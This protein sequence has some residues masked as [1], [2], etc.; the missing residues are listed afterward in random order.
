LGQQRWAELP[1]RIQERS[2]SSTSIFWFRCFLRSQPSETISMECHERWSSGGSNGRSSPRTRSSRQGGQF[3]QRRC[4]RCRRGTTIFP[5]SSTRFQE[6]HRGQSLQL[7]KRSQD[8]HSS[9]RETNCFFTS[10][11][12]GKL[13]SLSTSLVRYEE[14]TCRL[15]QAGTSL[16]AF[17]DPVSTSPQRP[18]TLSASS[19]S[20]KAAYPGHLTGGIPVSPFDPKAPV[21]NSHGSPLP[22]PRPHLQ[23]D[24]GLPSTSSTSALAS[25]SFY[26]PTLYGSSVQ[27]PSVPTPDQA[28]YGPSV[29]TYFNNFLP[30]QDETT[31]SSSDLTPT[32]VS[33][34]HGSGTSSPRVRYA[35]HPV[36]STGH[37]SNGHNTAISPS[38]LASPRPTYTP[39][40]PLASPR[41]TYT[42]LV[43]PSFRDSKDPSPF[44]SPA[45]SPAR[46]PA[47]SPPRIRSPPLASPP[48]E[49]SLWSPSASSTDSIVTSSSRRS[50]DSM[51][52]LL[53][54][55][56]SDATSVPDSPAS[57]SLQ[58]SG[59]KSKSKGPRPSNAL[60]FSH[61][62]DR[63]SC[64][65]IHI[66]KISH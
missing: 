66:L 30:L 21:I 3:R 52:S 12:K 31:H 6:S 13:S 32:P 57:G 46:S 48:S 63:V 8:V 27:Q 54:S 15:H 16:T 17:F 34:G 10:A 18:K 28:Y 41:P 25:K 58:L 39:P 23:P 65:S 61:F 19:S 1:N 55:P 49:E 37:G 33:H 9:S 40:S 36:G 11:I 44:A 59:E 47:G 51:N 14:L 62:L 43:P 60:E 42:P 56:E 29:S 53:S 4:S 50:E 7:L 64:F 22:S 2:S 5:T 45:D 20:K 38:P 26:S 35:S 24:F